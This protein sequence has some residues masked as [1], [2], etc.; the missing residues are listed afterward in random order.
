MCVSALIFLLLK[1]KFML[2]FL[3]ANF[4][5]SK[6]EAEENR[7]AGFKREVTGKQFKEVIN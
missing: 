1:Y 4:G 3:G 7:G 6:F 2:E 5:Q